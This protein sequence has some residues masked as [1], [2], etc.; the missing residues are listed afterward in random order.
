METT[1]SKLSD[2]D[3]SVLYNAKVGTFKHFNVIARDCCCAS[4]TPDPREPTRQLRK[5]ENMRLAPC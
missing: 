1:K 4:R 2:L 3:C 5:S